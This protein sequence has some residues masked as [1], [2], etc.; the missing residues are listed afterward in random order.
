MIPRPRQ[1]PAACGA[2]AMPLL[3]LATGPPAPRAGAVARPALVQRL[4][5]CA[6]AALAIVVGPPGYGKSTLLAE[7][8]QCDR[9]PFVWLALGQHEPEA[10]ASLMSRPGWEASGG[11]VELV[12][13]LG[14]RH[15]SFVLV[16]DDAHMVAPS[17]L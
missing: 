7:W 4:I 2:E 3:D 14:E 12:S 1:R 11:L 5:D 15:S 9:R 17:A 8:A 10:V 16:L 6:G 13:A